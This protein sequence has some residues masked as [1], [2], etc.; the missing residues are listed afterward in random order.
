[1]VE[2]IV[3]EIS[4]KAIGG[5]PVFKA[6][7]QITAQNVNE[8]FSDP[9]TVER[10]T[11]KLAEL[12]FRILYKSDIAI[13]A[14]GPKDLL[15]DVFHTSLQ[16]KE[17]DMFSG[18]PEMEQ[19]V[20]YFEGQSGVKTFGAP[21]GLEDLIDGVTLPEP[22]IFF[23]SP[24][25]LSV[26]YFH[27]DVPADVS[28][29]MNADKA[30]RFGFTGKCVKVAMPDTGFY[31]HPFYVHRGYRTSV[32]LSPDATDPNTDSHGHGTGEA[33][34]IF[35]TAPD[36]DFVAIKMGND[37]TLAFNTAVSQNPD[38]IT[39]SWGY[40]VRG[41]AKLPPN[42][43]PLEASVAAAVARGIVVCF[44]AGNG[45]IAFPAMHPDVVAVG[46]V[47]CDQNVDL[48]ASDYASS[49]TSQIYPDRN[50]PDICGL[51]GM[52]PKAI[53]I[54]LPQQAKS[55]I[56]SGNAGNVFP[57]GDETA[58]DDGWAAFSGTS[59]AS[60]QIAGVCALV[61]QACRR[62]SPKSIKSI[63]QKTATDVTK[64]S[65]NTASGGHTAAVGPDL[66]TGHGLVNAASAC[67]MARFRCLLIKVP[68]EIKVPEKVVPMPRETEQEIEEMEDL[69]MSE[70]GA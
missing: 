29:C 66:A 45:H 31:R 15:E 42:L 50:V 46:G 61:L 12:G 69:L 19:K 21:K 62:L 49:F 35:A 17:K 14:S 33:A 13:T 60:P 18:M 9:S 8:F 70:L 36:V 65:T 28:L 59:A 3:I 24:L 39:C 22:P 63:L 34:N 5:V 53:Y 23:E 52:K 64:G 30:H 6:S 25:P 67:L 51:V 43:A 10:A 11:R 47:H 54:M 58:L 57:S 1:M 32:V 4:P 26:K 27:L 20:S 55:S 44:S 2:D 48:R 40:D 41:L 68:P 7:G 56:D 38:V 16:T 37:A